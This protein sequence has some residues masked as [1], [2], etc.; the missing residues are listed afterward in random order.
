ML[1]HKSTSGNQEEVEAVHS[2]GKGRVLKVRLAKRRATRQALDRR[3]EPEE[4]VAFRAWRRGEDQRAQWDACP[5]R[6]GD[7]IR[8]VAVG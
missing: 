3:R 7:K 1:L 6:W 8:E 5:P 4:E 2:E